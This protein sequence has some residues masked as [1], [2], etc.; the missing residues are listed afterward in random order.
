[1]Q[2]QVPFARNQPS[3]GWPAGA[4]STHAKGQTMNKRSHLKLT[5]LAAAAPWLLCSTSVPA[6]EVLKIGV[7]GVM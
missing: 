1:M 7:Y 2:Y 6:Q 3:P 4:L 5:L